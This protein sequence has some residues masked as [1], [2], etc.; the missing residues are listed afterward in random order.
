ML[1]DHMSLYT[2]FVQINMSFECSHVLSVSRKGK[3]LIK[4]AEALQKTHL[5]INCL[6]K[7]S[8]MVNRVIHELS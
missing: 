7:C 4:V 2:R 5:H 8:V 3:G 1:Y 6:C